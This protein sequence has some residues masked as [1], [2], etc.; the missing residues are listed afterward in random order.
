MSEYY[1]DD[2]FDPSMFHQQGRGGVA[3]APPTPGVPDPEVEAPQ[4]FDP[5]RDIDPLAYKFFEHVEGSRHISSENKYKMQMGMIKDMSDIQGMRSKLDAQR[6]ES[7]I[8]E[9]RINQSQEMM[10]DT[11]RRQA[12]AVNASDMRTTLAGDL[13]AT[14]AGDLT[15]EQRRAAINAFEIENIGHLAADPQMA[16]MLDMTRRQIPIP[17]PEEGIYSPKDYE[18]MLAEGVPADIAMTGNPFLIGMARNEIKLQQAQQTADTRQIA[19]ARKAWATQVIGLSG[20][21]FSFMTED[22]RVLAGVGINSEGINVGDPNPYLKPEDHVRARALA[23]LVL[24]NKAEYEAFDKLS[25]AEKL[26]VLRKMQ[27]EALA[28]AVEKMSQDP[29]DAQ[30]DSLVP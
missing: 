25:D 3:T 5:R 23:R 2:T 26:P 22:E 16:L 15:D 12:A 20:K 13:Q 8:R 4:G 24:T 28:M 9:Q 30:A 1:D 11:R 7:V 17:V 19:G 10:R 27:I 18:N 14:M 29:L 21:E 6:H